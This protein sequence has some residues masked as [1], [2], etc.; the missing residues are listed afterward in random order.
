MKDQKG[1]TLLEVVIALSILA[2]IMIV[3]TSSW[4]GNFRRVKKAEIKTQA[5]HLLEKKITEIE[6]M[7][8]DDIK[9]LPEDLQ[10]GTFK[11]EALSK[12]SW[13]WETAE[14]QM[15]DIARLFVQDEGI[16]DEMS[17]K[18]ITQMK[19]Y[20][21]ESIREVKVTL[22]YKASPKAQEQRFSIAT[23][24]VDYDTPL[25]LGIGGS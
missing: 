24:L 23:I 4:K 22:I 13:E 17:L 21:E 8:K 10:K 7:Y 9:N 14:F 18:V 20:L 19:K 16:V 1:F 25:S 15:P 3:L 5:V 12:F 6:V 11:E 2:S